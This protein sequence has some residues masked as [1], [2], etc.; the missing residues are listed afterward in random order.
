MLRPLSCPE[1]GK[2]TVLRATCRSASE[3][4]LKFLLISPFR[5]QHCSH[6]FRAFR[7]G[8]DYPRNLLD[9]RQHRRIPVR[10]FLS[11][12]GRRLG[13]QGTVAII[14]L[15]GCVVECDAIV[16][17]DDIFYL[18]LYLFEGEPPVEVAAMVRSVGHRRIGFKFLRAAHDDKRLLDFLHN[19]GA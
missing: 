19:Q 6:R 5:C 9:R 10:L 1:C 13:G 3:H 8:R 17:I 4:L 16:Q 7:W 14:S 2:D 11:F 15:G 12:S 18:Q